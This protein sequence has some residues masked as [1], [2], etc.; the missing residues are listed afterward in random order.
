MNIVITYKEI[1][2]FIEK[3]YKIRPNFT[4][5]DEKTLE[6]ISLVFLCQPLL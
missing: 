2:D 6:V 1:S 3:R 4:T 5:I